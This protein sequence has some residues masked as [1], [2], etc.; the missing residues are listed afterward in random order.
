MV[1]TVQQHASSRATTCAEDSVAA[2]IRCCTV[3]GGCYGSVCGPAYGG[4]ADKQVVTGTFDGNAVTLYEATHECEAHGAR[5][6][7]AAELQ[8]DVC[9]GTGCGHDARHVWSSTSCVPPPP[10]QPPAHPP[11]S[12]P[13][14]SPPPPGRPPPLLPPVA[15]PPLAPPPAGPPPPPPGNPAPSAPPVVPLPLAP[16]ASPPPPLTPCR[17]P[18]HRSEGRSSEG[19]SGVYDG[20][21]EL[22]GGSGEPIGI[23][24]PVGSGTIEVGSGAEAPSSGGSS[25]TPFDAGSGTELAPPPDPLPECAPPPPPPPPSPSAPAPSA[26]PPCSPP[27]APPHPRPP[28]SPASPPLPPAPPPS[29]PAPAFPPVPPGLPPMSPPLWSQV[30]TCSACQQARLGYCAS[31]FRCATLSLNPCGGEHGAF[32]AADDAAVSLLVTYR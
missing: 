4:T 24:R 15:P 6:C 30:A 3:E 14:P 20:S 16:P 32:V 26:P 1:L 10:A 7:T 28:A 12:L 27:A 18:T 19:A 8:A 2:A 23:D 25:P 29:P 31:S 22:D 9:K 13:P 5:L 21:M 11:P 17:K